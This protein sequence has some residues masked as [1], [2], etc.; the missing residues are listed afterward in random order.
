MSKAVVNPYWAFPFQ[1]VS[2]RRISTVCPRLS[3]L[4]TIGS[5][6]SPEVFTATISTKPHGLMKT[7]Y[8]GCGPWSTKTR[9]YY[10]IDLNRSKKAFERL[11]EDWKRILISDS[12]RLYRKWVNDWQTCLAHLIRKA[13]GLSQR[14]KQNLKQFG[15]V[16]A[17]FLRQLVGFSPQLPSPKQWNVFYIHLLHTLRLYEPDKDDAGKLARQ[18]LRELD[19]LWVFLDH[20]GVEPTNNRAERALR[21]GVLW[22]KRSLGTQSEKE[23]R[24]V[25]RILSLKETCRLRSQPTFP[26]LADLIKSYFDN[27][28]PDLAWI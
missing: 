23:S 11:I 27:C 7:I 4:P 1:P 28:L 8:N 15:Q 25:E 21:F 13:V 24:W 22:R 6:R 18:V 5:A 19:S 17:A 20:P 14:R 26:M 12:Y 16:M 9:P 10:R 2:S 3:L